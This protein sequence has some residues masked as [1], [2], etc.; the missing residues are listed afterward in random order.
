MLLLL[1]LFILMHLT[2][3]FLKY[4]LIVIILSSVYSIIVVMIKA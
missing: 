3:S 4:E 1:M 2:K